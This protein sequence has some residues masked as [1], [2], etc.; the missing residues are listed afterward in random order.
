MNTSYVILPSSWS[1]QYHPIPQLFITGFTEKGLAVKIT[2]P[3]NITYI[4]KLQSEVTE[5]TLDHIENIMSPI[6]LF[7]S[8]HDPKTVICRSRYCDPVLL[9][10]L[11]EHFDISI[12][13]VNPI[14]AFWTA[15][16]TQPYGALAI[17]Q[18]KLLNSSDDKLNLA[19]K[20]DYILPTTLNQQNNITLLYYTLLFEEDQTHLVAIISNKDKYIPFIISTEHIP[21]TIKHTTIYSVE[22]YAALLNKFKSIISGYFPDIIIALTFADYQVVKQELEIEHICLHD[23]IN[24]FELRMSEF[25][26]DEE[27]LSIVNLYNKLA[28]ATSIDLQ[29]LWD[30]CNS[31]VITPFSLLNKPY[32]HTVKDIIYN[33]DEA[34]TK[35]D[36]SEKI[37]YLQAC[38]P[39]IYSDVRVYDYSNVYRNNLLLSP[40]NISLG[41][42]LENAPPEL[43]YSL[44]YSDY[45]DHKNISKLLTEEMSNISANVI[46]ISTTKI[47]TNSP[48][49]YSNVSDFL[50]FDTYSTLIKVDEQSSIIY[51][52]STDTI[53]FKGLAP[54][55]HIKCPAI[56]TIVSDYVK[57][58]TTEFTFDIHQFRRH[59]YILE[60]ILDDNYIPNSIE[61]K[62]YIAYGDYIEQPLSVYYIMT[63]YG[64]KLYST[65]DEFDSID[66]DFY[67]K[68]LM[69][70]LELL[71]HLPIY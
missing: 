36:K 66:Y 55:C 47:L 11:Q 2:L 34:I 16:N 17:S 26:A 58:L 15:T 9:Q 43:I 20:E 6:S 19:S 14:Q 1:Y 10:Q 64:P 13:P 69:P 5:K 32:H 23:Y 71:A 49:T 59:D 52:K 42:K 39:G 12:A 62:L 31:L 25:I 22:S 56:K 51:R 40:E 41:I 63:T 61:H 7:V 18:F 68:L 57:S 54:I 67:E 24:R 38:Q 48:I 4:I 3:L 53:E 60:T 28:K 45:I 29:P 27:Q 35:K 46:E 8:E 44:Y 33:M 50:L 65:V 30:A 37:R 21:L 70:H